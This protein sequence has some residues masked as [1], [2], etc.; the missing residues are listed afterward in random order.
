MDLMTTTGHHVTMKTVGIADLKARL[1]AHLKAVQKGHPITVMDRGRAVAQIVP[2]PQQG[3]LSIRKAIRSLHSFK[4]P[5]P[6]KGP[7][8]S[9]AALLEERGDR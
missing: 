9:L 4:L 8:D 7:I 1:S 3:K 2:I 5:P 6:V